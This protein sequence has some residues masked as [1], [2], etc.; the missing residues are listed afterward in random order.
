[1]NEWLLTLKMW[2]KIQTTYRA[3]KAPMRRASCL[4]PQPQP[5]LPTVSVLHAHWCIGVLSVPYTGPGSLTLRLEDMSFSLLG[6]FSPALLTQKTPIQ[7]SG[8]SSHGTFPHPA[9][10]LNWFPLVGSLSTPLFF[11]FGCLPAHNQQSNF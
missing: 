8:I 7:S 5:P 6:R 11:F 3:D 9:L 2:D 10:H 4:P 1:M